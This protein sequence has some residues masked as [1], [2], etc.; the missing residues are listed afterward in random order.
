MSAVLPQ[1]FVYMRYEKKGFSPLTLIGVIMGLMGKSRL[2][3]Y[4][5]DL[6]L[7]HFFAGTTGRTL[8]RICGQERG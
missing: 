8:D 7:E 3:K 5:Q 6:L 2:F 4:K 1:R